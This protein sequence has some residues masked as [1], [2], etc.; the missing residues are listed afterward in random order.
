MSKSFSAGPTDLERVFSRIDE[1]NVSVYTNEFDLAMFRVFFPRNVCK[2]GYLPQSCAFV[3]T[4]TP[5]IANKHKISVSRTELNTSLFSNIS[6]D[7]TLYVHTLKGTPFDVEDDGEENKIVDCE[8]I[9]SLFPPGN[10]KPL[11]ITTVGVYSIT[12]A[13][14]SRQLCDLIKD[15]SMVPNTIFD[16]TACVGGDTIGFALYLKCKVISLER[17]PVNFGAL[18]NNITAY[19]LGTRVKAIQGDFITDGY[20][21][22]EENKPEIVY[23]DP[24]WGGKD[25]SIK[26]NIELFLSGK[27]VKSIVTKILSEYSFV[28]RVIMKVPSNFNTGDLFNTELIRMK[29]F[30]IIVFGRP[31]VDEIVKPS[32]KFLQTILTPNYPMS[33]WVPEEKEKRDKKLPKA[34]YDMT[35]KNIHWGQRKL[36]LSEVDFF[37]SYTNR[38][39]K[40]T[41]VYAGAANGQH[42][43]LLLKL[44]PNLEFHLYDPAPFSPVVLS[45][46]ALKINPYKD[47]VLPVGFFTDEVASNY[48]ST[49]NL[50]FICDIRLAP[51]M[52]KSDPKYAALFE[53]K[54]D[55]DMT[56]QKDWVNIMKPK[57]SILKMRLP[58]HAKEKYEYLDG[59][60][61]FQIW[62]PVASTE[63]RLVVSRTDEGT[64][65]IKRYVPEVYERQ[66][67]Y[68]NNQM[69][70]MDLGKISFK[71]VGID[72]DGE[73][74]DLWNEYGILVNADCYLETT[75]F[76][77]YLKRIGEKVTVSN[78]KKLVDETSKWLYDDVLP[79]NAFLKK[80]E[81]NKHKK[82]FSK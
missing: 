55:Y 2:L 1:K 80:I 59:D 68:F 28:K 54:V 34:L 29:K 32:I 42:I 11:Q 40:Y 82:T 69:R 45:N 25:Y 70:Q 24:P 18:K 7:G 63:T 30:D 79:K 10:T 77:L 4:L 31:S 47:S 39:E 43:P 49:E 52:K 46:P 38:K 66:C 13:I 27:N 5:E 6:H 71:S 35:Y 8:Y 74:G 14:Y 57:F 56:I 19:N 16:A 33:I 60:V 67:A 22:I 51:S 9:S 53:E 73:F 41:I 62:A 17:D 64:F 44:F 36:H 78:V 81:V 50:L 26:K 37:M 15:K 20:K 3:N 58:Y 75:L 48:T 61:R 72:M 76:A 23:F 12:S 21:I 65:P